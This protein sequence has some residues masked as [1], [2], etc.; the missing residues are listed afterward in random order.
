MKFLKPQDMSIKKF[1]FS[2]I[3]RLLSKTFANYQELKPLV[4]GHLP[5][6]SLLETDWSPEP[7]NCL[8]LSQLSTPCQWNLSGSWHWWF[9]LE[10]G[11][12]PAK[13]TWPNINWVTLDFETFK[14]SLL[15]IGTNFKLSCYFGSQMIFNA[16]M[17]VNWTKYK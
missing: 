11:L 8:F 10:A 9:C 4:L 1:L 2:W 16:K 3:V 15:Y 12:N 5:S 6:L 13:Q 14:L 17:R 7:S